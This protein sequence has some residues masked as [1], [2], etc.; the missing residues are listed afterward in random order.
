M[1]RICRFFIRASEGQVVLHEHGK[2]LFA[3]LLVGLYICVEFQFE[4]LLAICFIGDRKLI[5]EVLP[6]N[7]LPKRNN[8]R[9]NL[10]HLLDVVHAL[11]T[12]LAALEK[13][14]LFEMKIFVGCLELDW[15]LCLG[16]L[17]IELFHRTH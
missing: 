6:R 1:L 3:A 14:S 4:G 17:E 8:W 9:V 5:A 10:N 16:T 2:D 7:E 12:G 15:L 13:I 11:L